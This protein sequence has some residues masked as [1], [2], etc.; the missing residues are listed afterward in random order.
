LGDKFGITRRTAI[1]TAAAPLLNAGPRQYIRELGPEDRFTVRAEDDWYMHSAGV[2]AFGDELVCTYRRSDEHIASE[3]EIWCARSNGGRTW[4]DH[5]MISRL[6]WEPDRAC[7]VAPQLSRTRDGRML[8]L[9]DR[10]EKLSRF[11]WPMLSQWQMKDRG[12]SN[13]LFLSSD[14][15][16]TWDG[17][18][19]TD[20]V[21]GEPGYIVELANGSWMYT[22]TD[23]KPTNAKKF[24]S[25]PWGPNYYRNTAVFSDDQGKTWRRTS[26]VS[27]DPLVGD[28]E[29][30]VAEY[31]PGKLIAITRI[32]DAGSS[33]GQPSRFVFS[34]DSGV[35]WTK[36]V[37]S[38]IYAHRA[39]VHPLQSGKLL[40]SYR[41][42]WGTTGTCVFVFDP[43]EKFSYQPNSVLWDESRCRLAGDAMEIRSAEG[44]EGAV[45]FT[46]YP[47]E[48]DDSAVEFEAELMV[49]EAAANGC[50]ISAGGW[51]RFLPQRVEI[52]DRPR[53]GFAIDATRWH[54]YRI[55]NRGRRIRLYA[56]GELKLQTA[57]DGIF[58]RLVHFGNRPGIAA[59]APQPKDGQ[60]TRRPLREGGYQQNVSVSL[61]RAISVT[62]QN[63]RDHSV[64]W[65]WWAKDGFPDQFRRDRV[66]RLERNG[67]FAAGNSGYS[68]W[69]QLPDG[70]V[71]VVDYTSGDPPRSHPL[72]R[73]YRLRV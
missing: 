16:R 44:R 10:G 14:R 17:P 39:A 55:V 68:N 25:M 38:P 54:K 64:E 20:E 58:T 49:R 42:A 26:L 67:T 1:L 70:T 51:I 30:G 69:A 37:L 65:Q 50:L 12:M 72:L 57:T 61:W 31:A 8:L 59:T 36:P 23:S 52:A 5:R 41:N 19:K 47:V 46:L 4:T 22:R 62:V 53:E 28:A 66:I 43:R 48:D 18:H 2:V 29:V 7:W 32:G 35:T 13:H 40:V 3:V 63:R 15:G 27:D 33:L 56:D 6:G 60:T 71:V 73:A 24:P 11:D 21:G 34:N 9:V 45:E